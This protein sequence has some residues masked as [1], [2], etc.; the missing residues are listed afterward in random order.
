MDATVKGLND[1][2]KGDRPPVAITFHAF[3]FMVGLGMLF[4]LLVLIGLF[5]W[6]RLEERRWY[7]RVMLFAIPLPFIAC[8]LGWTVTEVGRQPWI[9]YG[10]LRTDQAASPIA[11][12]QVGISLVAFTILYTLIGVLAYWL[13]A[14]TVRKGPKQ[15][16]AGANHGKEG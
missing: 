6:K 10:L 12:S 8:A 9:V 4:V 15:A 1:I 14:Q 11:A 7:L 3:R 13:M 5:F 16:M 2:P